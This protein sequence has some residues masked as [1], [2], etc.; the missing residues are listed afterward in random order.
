VVRK[1]AFLLLTLGASG[2][3]IWTRPVRTMRALLAQGVI[4]AGGMLL[5]SNRPSTSGL[6]GRFLLLFGASGL[7][8][9]LRTFAFDRAPADLPQLAVSLAAMMVG[10]GI[11]VTMRPAD[12]SLSDQFRSFAASLLQSGPARLAR[13]ELNVIRFAI[14]PPTPNR[15]NAPGETKFWMS[16]DATQLAWAFVVVALVESLALHLLVGALAHI[17]LWVVAILADVTILYAIGIVRSLSRVPITL[18]ANGEIVIGVGILFRCQTCVGNVEQAA[19]PS[20]AS[21]DRKRTLNGNLLSSPN[22]E[23]HLRAPVDAHILGLFCRPVRVIR[24]K[25]SD[26]PAFLAAMEDAGKVSR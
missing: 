2:F 21:V 7:A 15:I 17:W 6:A 3:L 19:V 11:F 18:H 4:A 20:G 9:A 16:P 14:I 24:L 22:V 10:A 26:S 8:L 23:M 13:S 25:I 1:L 12:R 5:S